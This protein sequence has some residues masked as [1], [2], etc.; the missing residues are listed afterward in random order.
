MWKIISYLAFIYFISIGLYR[1]LKYGDRQHLA[2]VAVGCF[3]I[4]VLLIND[5][6][7][8]IF[9]TSSPLRFTY[10]LVCAFLDVILGLGVIYLMIKEWQRE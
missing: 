9:T 10:D 6:G 7:G 2:S 1:W 3:G 4:V 5:Y 8:L